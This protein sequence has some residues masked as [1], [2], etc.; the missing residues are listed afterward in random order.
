METFPVKLSESSWVLV[1][2]Y[3]NNYIEMQF[4]GIFWFVSCNWYFALN[5]PVVSL[6][7]FRIEIQ[8]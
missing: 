8:E 6:M 1:T 7:D 4:G 3:E 5:S 2:F